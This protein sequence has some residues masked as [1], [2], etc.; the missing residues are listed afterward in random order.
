M[1]VA[2]DGAVRGVKRSVRVKT[3]QVLGSGSVKI[4]KVSTDQDLSVSEDGDDV[5]LVIESRASRLDEVEVNA[6][7]RLNS[8]N[9]SDVL[10]LDACDGPSNNHLLVGLGCKSQN[11]A[12]HRAGADKVKSSVNASIRQI[13][14]SQF[15]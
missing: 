2:C 7:I 10:P 5:D 4:R 6:S 15:A 3:S 12:V 13:N 14:S 9:A 8:G 11:A 1:W